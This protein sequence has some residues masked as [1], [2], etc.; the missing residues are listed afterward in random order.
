MTAVPLEQGFR[1]LRLEEDAS[2][3]RHAG[4]PGS[5]DHAP[6]WSSMDMR[7]PSKRRP[8]R[9]GRYTSFRIRPHLSHS[10]VAARVTRLTPRK[11][12]N[13]RRIDC[14]KASLTR[15]GVSSEDRRESK[16]LVW[17]A[18]RIESPMAPPR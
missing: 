14:D 1:V 18:P 6:E 16:T 15:A 8:I 2:D 3:A 9:L 10:R 13:K 4:S 17:I 5:C 11:I 7:E 12:Q